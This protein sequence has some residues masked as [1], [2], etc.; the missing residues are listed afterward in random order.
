MDEKG[1]TLMVKDV[2]SYQSTAE[3]FFDRIDS[4]PNPT[5]QTCENWLDEFS[6]GIRNEAERLNTI[7]PVLKWCAEKD[8]MT[9]ALRNELWL[10]YESFLKGDL[11]KEYEDYVGEDDE[12]CDLEEDRR[13]V[14]H[15]LKAAYVLVYGTEELVEEP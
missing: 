7:L 4:T 2:I 9:E 5:A 1:E 14:F 10:Y 15:D 12:G 8:F 13:L 3:L 11:D 6:T